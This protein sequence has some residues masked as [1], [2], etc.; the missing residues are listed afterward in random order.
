MHT[1]VDA[2]ERQQPTGKTY[3]IIPSRFPPIG[4]FEDLVDADE[5]ETL[6]AIEALTNDRLRAEAGD[7]NL[8]PK[9]EWLFLHRVQRSTHHNCHPKNDWQGQYV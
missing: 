1:E 6:F 2:I 8:V 4:I 3:R 7:L 9:D 5:L